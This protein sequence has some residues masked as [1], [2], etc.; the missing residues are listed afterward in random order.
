[1]RIVIDLQGAQTASR[2]R[3]I[4]RYSL[5][6]T[7][8][9]VRNRGSHEIVIVLN[10]AFPETIQPI[11]A[12]FEGLLPQENIRIWHVD[13][14]LLSV[15]WRGTNLALASE[16]IYEAYLVSLKPDLIHVMSLFEGFSDYGV[17]SIKQ[18]NQTIPV[19]VSFYDLIPLLNSEKYLKPHPLYEQYYLKKLAHLKR[20]SV[21]LAISESSRQ[22]GIQHLGLPA[23][24]LVNVSSA[25]DPQFRVLSLSELQ[26][27]EI[28]NQFGLHRSFLMHVGEADERK[29]LP[30][31][32]QAYAR[33][34]I[35]LRQTY[36]LVFVGN[37]I[38]DTI[39]QL[40]MVAKK[41]GLQPDELIFKG[42]VSNEDLV[43]LYNLAT[44]CVFPSW[45][46]GFGLPVLEAMSCGAAVICSNTTSMQEVV[47]N[48]LAYFDCGSIESIA[49]KIEQTL[50]SED[51]R[52]ALIN[53]GL[54][55]AQDFSWDKSACRSIV[56]FEQCYLEN[57]V[58]AP[59]SVPSISR[60]KLA[61]VSPLP[62]ARTGIAYYSAQLLPE[63]A[64]Y[65]NIELV[66]D[67]PKYTV[68]PEIT[69]IY[70]IRTPQWLRD[71][72]HTI[73]RVLY[74][75]GNSTFHYF[76]FSLLEEIP[77]VVVLHDFFL[78]G[79]LSYYEHEQV[80]LRTWSTALYDSHGYQAVWE[81]FNENMTDVRMKYPV[82]LRIFQH[83]EGIISHSEQARSLAKCWYGSSVSDPGF[84]SVVPLLR[85]PVSKLNKMQARTQLTLGK[86]DFIICS[87]GMLDPT[88]L[89]AELLNAW[90][91]STLFS[92]PNC[93][94][95]FVGEN[96]GGEYGQQ[97]LNTIQQHG[98]ADRI[99][100][101]G[102]TDSASYDAYLAA[103]DMAVQLRALSRGETSA[104]VLDCMNYGLPTIVNAHGSMAELP[105]G[106]VL[107]LANDFTQ[108]ELIAA[109]EC[110]WQDELSRQQLGQSAKHVMDTI[111]AP[112]QCAQ[113]YRD[114]IERTHSKRDMS[115][116]HLLHAI[117]TASE[118][119]LSK[120]Q[121][122]A[123]VKSIVGW[124]PSQA[125]PRQLL[126]DISATYRH[127]LRTGI[128]RVVRSLLLELVQ[129]SGPEYRIE[130]VYLCSENGEWHY[131]YARSYMFD[132]LKLPADILPDEKVD[133]RSGDVIMT[134]DLFTMNIPEIWGY[135]EKLRHRGVSLYFLIY[136]LLPAV[137]PHAFPPRMSE[138]F[139][140]WM[141]EVIDSNGAICI[142][143]AVAN[144]LT[145]YY[146]AMS[147]SKTTPFKVSHFHLGADIENSAPSRGV[148]KKLQKIL[149]L[150]KVAPT[151]LMVGTIEP[152]K[153]YAQVLLAFEELWARNLPVN[154]IIVGKEGWKG[155]PQAQRSVIPELVKKLRRHPKKRKNIFW[156]EDA[157]DDS[158]EKL[159]KTSTCLLVASEAEGFGLPLIEAARHGLPMIVRDIPVF[160]EIAGD[161]AFYFSGQESQDLVSSLTKWL[162]LYEQQLMPKSDNMP[163]L[164]WAESAQQ[165][166]ER[167]FE[168]I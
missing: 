59:S 11:R 103:A 53:H 152:R 85:A 27:Q 96:H 39:S 164:R 141:K 165:F 3:G 93:V 30:A 105:D 118:F 158:L 13:P 109:L 132:L 37:L 147:P 163:W 97:L 55:K 20:A 42:Y 154:L 5:M 162:A 140:S 86:D 31:L 36:H 44:V 28:R 139:Q 130:P 129:T 62:P 102:W 115:V 167:L 74:H 123:V 47:D 4:G 125:T 82:N 1:M 111:H 87:F 14:Q 142:S 106:A 126:L 58:K 12:F 56:A 7:Q 61:F 6:L 98:G 90:L 18:Y 113:Q 136:D 78:S 81:R 77:G 49:C 88:K 60:P 117:I 157:S 138:T 46:E 57:K 156:L 83:A 84:W 166:K 24:A 63:L 122:L 52:L 128:E 95:I 149:S 41:A 104:A 148:D 151:F 133:V 116:S 108:K 8:A 144:Q 65:Y 21:L 23:T 19:S 50:I 121:R 155:L 168:M 101:T 79:V 15:P 26:V 35:Q 89:N 94:L 25:V 119:Q 16:L 107:K 66:T 120:I 33:L 34:P 99:F 40:N 143:K 135:I 22:E 131:R 29:N 161:H 153:G 48:P 68:D 69:A 146:R 2:F 38:P 159:Y 67:Q 73:E 17:T 80:S 64:K 10:G 100:I 45:Q 9:I 51:F 54:Q 137:L 110:M 127:N 76:M 160:R 91:N 71:N 114:I 124:F 43:K 145:S 150:V 72:S 92:H 32:I 70:N 112:Q 75:F 134:L